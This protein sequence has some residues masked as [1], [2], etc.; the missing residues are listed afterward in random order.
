MSKIEKAI[1]RA[2]QKRR[3]LLS[4]RPLEKEAP[5]ASQTMKGERPRPLVKT[6]QYTQTRT[7]PADPAVLADRKVMAAHNGRSRVVE[8]YRL[9]RA[10]VLRKARDEGWN[11][12]MVTS[13]G[14][15][16]GKTLTAINLA[17]AIS[18]ELNETALLVEADLREPNIQ[19][20]FGLRGQPGLT[21]HLLRGVPL[22]NLLINP[23]IDRFVF[24]PGGQ[25][26]PNSAEILGSP[27]M[28]DLVAEMK[29]RYSD[30]YVVFDLPPLFECAD[31]LIVSDYVDGVLLV[32]EAYKTTT[33]QLK[34]AAEL[35]DGRRIIGTVLNKVKTNEKEY[36][37]Y[38]YR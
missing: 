33:D 4:G 21:D 7:M 15:G 26:I 2:E 12:L 8:E 23:E 29:H 18:Q 37:R 30:R 34:K 32:V 28:R 1:E 3:S 6:I 9:L 31:P 10:Q 38:Y 22:A 11:T 24:L 16:E 19:R 20:F 14:K 25:S 27:K 13:V 36:Y 17:F 5:E 35:L